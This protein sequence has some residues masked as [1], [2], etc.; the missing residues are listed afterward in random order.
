MACCRGPEERGSSNVPVAGVRPSWADRVHESLFADDAR[1]GLV[2]AVE[3][4]AAPVDELVSG[5]GRRDAHG[6][7]VV[8]HPG[9]PLRNAARALIEAMAMPL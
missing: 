5:P 7:V 8:E 3:G 4:D 9:V 2:R 6:V 1:V